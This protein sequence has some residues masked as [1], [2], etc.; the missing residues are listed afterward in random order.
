M[1]LDERLDLLCTMQYNEFA[2]EQTVESPLTN[3]AVKHLILKNAAKLVV[4]CYS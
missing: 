2:D 3:P 1:I 4:L